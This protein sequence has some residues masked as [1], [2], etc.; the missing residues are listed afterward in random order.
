MVHGHVDHGWRWC[1]WLKC[2]REPKVSETV[3]MSSVVI[4]EWTCSRLSVVR[5]TAEEQALEETERVWT[6]E[7][8]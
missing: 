6:E 7:K 8:S 5:G 4:S 1:P 2:R 3:A